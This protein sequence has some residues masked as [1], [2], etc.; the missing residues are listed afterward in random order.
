M[1]SRARALGHALDVEPVPV[2]DELP[3]HDRHAVADVRAGVL[4]RERVHG[5]RAQRVLE[6]RARRPVAQRLVDARRVEREVLA[7]AAR[8]DGDPRV[9]ADE[10]AARSSAISTLRR[11]DLEDALAR[12]RTSRGRARPR[13]RRGGPAGCPSAPRRRGARRRPRPR[14]ADRSSTSMLMRSPSRRQPAGAAAEDDALEQRVAHHAV[15][16]VGAARDLAAGVEALERRLG[17]LVDD[18]AAVLVVED[19]IGEDPLRQRVD[20]RRA[21]AAEHVRQRDLRRRASAIRVVSR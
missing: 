7:D 1:F 5:V 14:A 3:V 17:V 12:T 4:A 9:L 21:V 6:R 11:I 16:P 8:V 19:G 15:A 20:A 10:V 18:E 2:R 13:A